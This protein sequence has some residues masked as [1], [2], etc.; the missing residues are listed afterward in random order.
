MDGDVKLENHYSP[1]E[2]IIDY[3]GWTYLLEDSLTEK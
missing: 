2:L 1:T 3:F